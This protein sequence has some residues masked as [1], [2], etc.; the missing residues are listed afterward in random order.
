MNDLYTEM[1][2]TH[3]MQKDWKPKSGDLV[4]IP[5]WLPSQ[6][7]WQKKLNDT[8]PPTI[9]IVLLGLRDLWRGTS[10]YCIEDYDV[11]W[12]IYTSLVVYGIVWDFDK[13]EWVDVK[14]ND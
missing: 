9:D 7:D 11:L 4:N 1:M 12:C 2:K 8:A 5:L 6:E 10:K 14:K 3:P 13:K